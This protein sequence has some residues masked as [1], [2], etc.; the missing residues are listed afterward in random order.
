MLVAIKL[1]NVRQKKSSLANE[2]LVMRKLAERQGKHQKCFPK[3]FDNGL[4]P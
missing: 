2:G 1:E 4:A 3:Y